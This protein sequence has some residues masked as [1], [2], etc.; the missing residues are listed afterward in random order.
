MERQVPTLEARTLEADRLEAVR[1]SD[2]LR[3]DS[4]LVQTKNSIYA[5]RVLGDGF[6]H[7]SGGWFDRNGGPGQIVTISGCTWGGSAIKQDIVAAR[8]LFLEFGNHVVTTRIR[9]VALIRAD[10]VASPGDPAT[11]F[12]LGDLPRDTRPN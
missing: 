8:G 10:A 2:L 6:Y 4:L 12:T 9:D 7:I 11:H 5:I 1:K 3:G